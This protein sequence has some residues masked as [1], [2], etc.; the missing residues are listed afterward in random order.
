M[1]ILLLFFS[2]FMFFCFF[3]F[4]KKFKIDKSLSFEKKNVE[5]IVPRPAGPND[6]STQSFHSQRKAMQPILPALTEGPQSSTQSV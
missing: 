6:Q 5:K 2:C 3:L 1:K 4:C